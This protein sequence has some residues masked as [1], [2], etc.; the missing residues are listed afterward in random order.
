MGSTS[1]HMNLGQHRCCIPSCCF[2]FL[3][4]AVVH[5]DAHFSGIVI[6]MAAW[7]A[8]L[9]HMPNCLQWVNEV[10]SNTH[11]PSCRS[12]LHYSCRILAVFLWCLFEDFPSLGVVG[13]ILAWC[14]AMLKCS[15]LVTWHKSLFP[16]RYPLIQLT[17]SWC[18]ASGSGCVTLND[19]CFLTEGLSERWKLFG[20][21][22]TIPND[23]NPLRLICAVKNNRWL[24]TMTGTVTKF[25]CN[26]RFWASAT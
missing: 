23:R 11:T 9:F 22:F 10:T 25:T 2:W 26:D 5:K 18:C 6:V 12:T 20:L 7:P 4:G 14:P 17:P 15:Q 13:I 21:S 1:S 24:C 16:G 19:T 3:F 8:V